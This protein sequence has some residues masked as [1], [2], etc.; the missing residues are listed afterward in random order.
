MRSS[1]EVAQG[2]KTAE[3]FVRLSQATRGQQGEKR[4]TT[5]GQEGAHQDVSSIYFPWTLCCSCDDFLKSKPCVQVV[6]RSEHAK[7][8]RDAKD[9]STEQLYEFYFLNFLDFCDSGLLP[10]RQGSEVK[11]GEK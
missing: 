11:S 10:P 8:S 4:G 5:S 9:V 3:E 1:P 7:A 2:H 6:G